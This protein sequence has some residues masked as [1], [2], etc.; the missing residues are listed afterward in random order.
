M[1]A[2]DPPTGGRENIVA[3]ERGQTTI[4]DRV[5]AKIAAQAARE[6]L[7]AVPAGGKAPRATVTVHHDAAR[8]RISLELDY[9][10]DIGRQCG[11]VRHR[12][13]ERVKTLAG[14]DVPEVAVLVERL[15]SDHLRSAAQGRTR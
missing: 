14:M 13:A 15:H 5:V 1:A 10:S 9:P 11:A 12:V 4:A 6:A 2:G 8:V 7:D 3:G